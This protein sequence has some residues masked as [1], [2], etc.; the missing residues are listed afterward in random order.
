MSIL[1]IN[2]ET[3]NLQ[4]H[5]QRWHCLRRPETVAPTPCPGI[6]SPALSS[7]YTL[8]SLDVP[9]SESLVPLPKYLEP[10]FV[11]FFSIFSLPHIEGI[12]EYSEICNVLTIV[13]VSMESGILYPSSPIILHLIIF[14]SLKKKYFGQINAMQMCNGN[15]DVWH[16]G[17]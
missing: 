9:P 5:P 17:S 14:C 7:L 6:W 1:L 10:L 11:S 13:C 2:R 16:V 4:S 8:T 3:K 15:V 12:Y